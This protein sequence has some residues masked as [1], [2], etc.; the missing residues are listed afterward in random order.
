MAL[1]KTRTLS[2]EQKAEIADEQQEQDGK[3]TSPDEESS[4]I[5]EDVKMSKIYSAE[6]PVSVSCQL[7][8]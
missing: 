3:S 2:P 7:F 6:I 8:A 5:V 1:W 4:L